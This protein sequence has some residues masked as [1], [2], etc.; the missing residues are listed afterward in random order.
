MRQDDRVIVGVDDL[1]SL[2]AAVSW[3]FG[4]VGMPVPMSRNW[5]TPLSLEIDFAALTRTPEAHREASTATWTALL[6]DGTRALAQA[7]RWEEAARRAAGHHG[8][9]ARLLDGRQAK[10]IA[11]LTGGRVPQAAQLI[12]QATVDELWEHAVQAV[13]RV[14]CQRANGQQSR[15][16]TASM[17]AI[18]RTLVSEAD[19]PTVV[20]R[21]RIGLTALGLCDGTDAEH[22]RA[23][24]PA[25]AAATTTDAYADR[26]LL[27]SLH[28]DRL[29]SAVQRTGLQAL[30][31]DSGL[32]AGTIPAHPGDRLA[33]ASARAEAVLAHACSHE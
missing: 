8:I 11:P 23:L 9:G 1:A 18:A 33:S 2:A 21:T 26:D 10:I 13:L 5:V 12:E 15:P 25:L 3:T 6:A 17:T 14:M 7:G 31:R 29:L 28:A 30:I 24:G 27:A 20:A 16:D 22:G 32:G 19:P 4:D